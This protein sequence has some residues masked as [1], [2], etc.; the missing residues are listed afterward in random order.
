MYANYHV[1]I[2]TLRAHLPPSPLILIPSNSSQVH[3]VRMGEHTTGESLFFA[4]IGK[5]LSD[6]LGCVIVKVRSSKSSWLLGV[7]RAVDTLETSDFGCDS[8]SPSDLVMWLVMIYNRGGVREMSVTW[9][10]RRFT[11]PLKLALYILSTRWSSSLHRNIHLETRE[12]TS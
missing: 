5:S 8:T 10:G 1:S 9:G 2:N 6:I 3:W 12:T 7:V 4:H 11:H